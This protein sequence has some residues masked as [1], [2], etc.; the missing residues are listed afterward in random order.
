MKT[1]ENF[2]PPFRIGR[3]QKRAVLDSKGIE[4]CIFSTGSEEVAQLFCDF[5]NTPRN[6]NH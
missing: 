5:L 2:T 4:V 1:I 6:S 3:K